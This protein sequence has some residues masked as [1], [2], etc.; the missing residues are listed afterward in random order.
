VA[1]AL[2]RDLLIFFDTVWVNFLVVDPY[3]VV[4]GLCSERLNAQTFEC[5]HEVIQ[6]LLASAN[7]AGS[8]AAP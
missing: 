6:H 3:G 4:D 7:E 2:L 5:P 8:E 1:G